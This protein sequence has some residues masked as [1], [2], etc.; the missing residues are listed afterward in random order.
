MV[1]LASDQTASLRCQVEA[2][3]AEGIT[4]RWTLSTGRETSLVG[5]EAPVSAGLSSTLQYTPRRDADFGQLQCWAKN[6]IGQQVQPCV[7]NIVKEGK[8]RKQALLAVHFN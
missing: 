7:F 3:P 6:E 8:P 1:V 2:D 4:F 5:G